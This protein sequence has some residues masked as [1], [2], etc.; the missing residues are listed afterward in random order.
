MAN[1]G[2]I[3]FRLALALL[4][5]ECC[6]CKGEPTGEPTDRRLL[7]CFEHL[8]RALVKNPSGEII[9]NLVAS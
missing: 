4:T 6:A 9:V 2:S 8:E 7:L 1:V 3:T 5:E